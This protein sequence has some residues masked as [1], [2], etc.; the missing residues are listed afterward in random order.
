MFFD[1]PMPY[2][3]PMD[4]KEQLIQARN[5]LQKA[6]DTA[7][8]ALPEYR[9]LEAVERAIEE[10]AKAEKHGNEIIAEAAQQ[11]YTSLAIAALREA[12]APLSTPQIIEYIGRYR[13]I[14]HDPERAKINISSALSK[15]NRLQ[16]ISWVTGRAWWIVGERV[17]K[18]REIDSKSPEE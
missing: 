3:G 12:G 5:A 13:P 2:G 18:P 1:H 16:S 17:P 9:A 10:L 6:V 15:D 14:S 7:L 11:S 8:E 4:A